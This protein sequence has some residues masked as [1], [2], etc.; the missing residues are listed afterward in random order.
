MESGRRYL[1]TG[2]AAAYVG[3]SPDTLNRMRV[4][5]AGPRYAKLG[6]RVVYALHRLDLWMEARGRRSRR[7]ERLPGDDRDCSG[8]DAT[9]SW[10]RYL[11]TKAA[12]AHVGLSPGKLNR[13][14]VEGCGPRYAK[15]G[16]RVLYDVHDLDAWIEA[17]ERRFTGEAGGQ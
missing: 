1:D 5:G 3:L 13:M 7:P 16:R 6:R 12:A 4:E 11:D 10:R 2:A 9:A 17:H 14:R 8:P 15:K